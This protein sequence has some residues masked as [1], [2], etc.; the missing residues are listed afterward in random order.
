M[1]YSTI[2]IFISLMLSTGFD[3]IDGTCT[4]PSTW[5]GTWYDSTISASNIVFD[6]TNLQV[7]SGWTITAYASTVTSWTCVNHDASNNLILFKG[8]QFVNLFSSLQNAFRCLKYE[9]INDYS[10][11]Y[12]IYADIQVNANDARV[13]IESND[14]SVTSWPVTSPYC[15]NP[16]DLGT[17]EYAV[18]VKDG[19]LSSVKQ[20]CPT[21]FLGTFA[22]THND[23]SSDTCGTGS[24]WD[25]CTDRQVMTV[26]YT[27]CSTKQYY[28]TGGEAYCVHST[29]SGSTYYTTVVNIDS[30]VDFST[31][32]RFT[33]YAVTSSGSTVYASDSK[34][35]CERSQSPT[36]KQTD[37]TGTIV[38]TPYITCPFTDDSETASAG[39]NVAIIAGIVAAILLLIIALVVGLIL[40]KKFKKKHKTMHQTLKENPADMALETYRDALSITPAEESRL[41]PITERSNL[42]LNETTEATTPLPPINKMSIEEMSPRGPDVTHINIPEKKQLEPLETYVP[43]GLENKPTGAAP[44]PPISQIYK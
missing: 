21:P 37:G 27:Q 31:T 41:P 30:S 12:Y 5:D 39:S 1:H 13:Y 26:N 44:L 14:P 34:G 11:V 17:E 2:S 35:Q 29:S 38:Y 4:L 8:D 9:K 43:N 40:Y 16:S 23:G 20:Y 3:K 7:T 18:L 32:Y 22:Y 24:V 42:P 36:A 25:V 28:S 33:C 19:Q 15:T 10:Y 6:N